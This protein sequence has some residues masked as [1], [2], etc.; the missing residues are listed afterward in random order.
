MMKYDQL[1]LID[2]SQGIKSSEVMHNDRALQEQIERER[3]AIAGYGINFGL[4]LSLINEFELEITT[5]TIVDKDGIEKVIEG[6][7]FNIEL[8]NLIMRKQRLFSSEQGVLVLDDIPYSEDRTE[9]SQYA[10]NSAYWGIEAI[11][12]DNPSVELEVASID[13][14]V[15]YTNAKDMKRA[16]IVNYNTAYDR[17]DTVYIN[18]EY[19]IKISAGIDSTTASAYIPE[20]CKYV[21][22][23]IKVISNFFDEEIGYPKAKASIIK[24]FNNRRTVY[25]DLNNN[26]YLCGVPFESLL[27]I[28]F[29][30]PK[31]PK[32]GMLW[33]D[34]TTNKLKIWRRTDFFMF[35]DI[36]TY[37]SIDP[38][39]PQKF[40]TSVGYFKNQLSVYL[41]QRNLAGEKVWTKLTDDQLEYYTDLEESEKGNKES[42]EFR[43]IPKLVS[44]SNI[45]YVINRYDDSYYWVPIN[46][47]SYVSTFEYK[48][49][50]PSEDCSELVEYRPGLNLSEMKVDR[51]N[52][53]LKH[54]IF[55]PEELN[56]RF[57]PYK[58]ELSI[59]VDQIPLHR[60]QFVEL[61]VN[62]I[63]DSQELTEL[64]TTHYG[65]TT[66]YLQEL[67][68]SYQDVG[69]GFKFVNSLDK[70]AFVEVNVQHRVNDSILKNKFQRSATFSKTQTVIY[71][72]STGITPYAVK[73]PD[74]IINTVIPYKYK[75]E[76]LDV[77]VDGKRIKN[78]LVKEITSGEE[79]MGAFCKSFAINPVAVGL[80][81]GS[82]ITY[83]IT[84]NVYSY[85]HV[86]SAI[87][88]Y[89][90]ELVNKIS[91]LETMV[92]TLKRQ[93]DGLLGN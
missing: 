89:Q 22:G 76:Q 36:V 55:R 91:D 33:Y 15:L 13:G 24:E 47:T 14:N 34:M 6:K 23:F 37:T 38:N 86:E 64:V 7:R 80:A 56:L 92:N 77:Y 5:G 82:E 17:I 45:K 3:L 46:D 35:T 93:M 11:Y 58:N 59:M 69:L 53:D 84:T 44:N 27:R 49:W 90:Q 70:P 61:T 10:K 60:D 20:D 54:F 62:S 75:E 12:E 78:E 73:T 71:N 18:N 50:S 21:L 81:D 8:P 48:L 66:D 19:E 88:E 28:Y 25:T 26:L 63:L 30:E 85:D 42:K 65:Y 39:N 16:V 43:I 87:R 74:I 52:H 83:K 40:P 67:K 68:E 4:E 79:L 29:E 32:E 1:K 51:P 41:E 31:E 72:S 9:P 2:F 57:T